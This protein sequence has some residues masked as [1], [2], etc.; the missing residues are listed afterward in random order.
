M[1]VS[2]LE[3]LLDNLNSPVA[4]VDP[5][6]ML[7]FTNRPF[8]EALIPTA[9]EEVAGVVSELLPLA[10][11]L[12]ECRRNGEDCSAVMSLPFMNSHQPVLVRLAPLAPED[13]ATLTA[14]YLEKPP[15]QNALQDPTTGLL[16]RHSLREITERELARAKREGTPLAL[17]FVMLHNFKQINQ[18]HGHHV[19]DLL[20]ENTGIRCREVV[21]LT[22]SVFRWEGT[23]LVVLLPSLANNL[24]VAIVA[25]KLYEAATMPY[26][27]RDLDIAP[28]CHIGVALFPSDGTTFEDLLNSANSAV[29]EA[30]QQQE[31][32][33]IYERTVHDA[34]VERLL[35]KTGIQRGFANGEFML[36]FQPI[37]DRDG[38]PRGGEALIRWQHPTRG[39]LAPGVFL[40]IAEESQ[41]ITLI[42]KVA[43]YSACRCLAEWA[44][45]N[46]FFLTLNVSAQTLA[47]GTLPGLITHAMED[48]GLKDPSSLRLEL[49]ESQLLTHF[50][51]A[52]SVLEELA[53]MGVETW[54]DDFGTGQSSLSYLKRLPVTTV[55]V[56]REFIQ[57]LITHRED[58]TYL[59]TITATIR[60]R[61]KRI[62]I[63]GVASEDH[64]QILAGIETDYL[65]GYHFGVPTTA[66]EF[67]RLFR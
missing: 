2:D 27:F 44:L 33:L 49:T 43:L 8:R 50:T 5:R 9:R 34:A 46:D 54:I 63:E 17:L 31:H 36:F 40:A 59:E 37:V 19:G 11:L 3:A 45:P 65:Q 7:V 41:L 30:E 51:V 26:R 64:Y 48:A 15:R 28:G 39:T 57:D 14:L 32:Y 38:V 4:L 42:D 16:N 53:K 62:V 55:K 58:L 1:H 66:E 12:E 67:V 60:A 52:Q 6:N 24:D 18:Y 61:K 20:L 22:D 25:E 13:P 35:M 56:D 21:R 29:I 47:D 23:N 10:A